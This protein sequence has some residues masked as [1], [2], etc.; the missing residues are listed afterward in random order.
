MSSPT[1]QPLRA[2]TTRLRG[3]KLRGWRKL[4]GS[5]WGPPNDPQFYGDLE[6]DAGT[7]VEHLHQLRERTGTHVT[8]THAVGRAVAHGLDRVPDL[9]GSST[10]LQVSGLVRRVLRRQRPHQLGRALPRLPGLRPREG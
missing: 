7:L 8:L 10:G 4:A 1:P 5:F 3:R 6:L 9:R 2:R